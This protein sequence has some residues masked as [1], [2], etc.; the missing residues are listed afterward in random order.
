MHLFQVADGVQIVPRGRLGRA[1][2][3]SPHAREVPQG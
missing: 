3:G 2:A 1:G